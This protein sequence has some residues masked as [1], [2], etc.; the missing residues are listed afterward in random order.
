MSWNGFANLDL[1]GVEAD[2]YAP[3]QTGEY[4]AVCTKAE[5][6]T[7]AN[8]TDKRVVVSLKDEDGA[9]S[10]AAGFN[11]VHRG[12]K[13]AQEIGLKQL[14]SFLVAGKHPTPDNPGDIESLVGL[15]CRIYVGMGKPYLKDGNQVQRAEVKRFIMDGDAALKPAAKKAADLDDEI[16]F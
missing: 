1:S 8:G 12:S 14:K 4:D 3:L 9:G 2:D 11:V 13:Q 15:R 16:P 7:A 5:I 10:I 6:K